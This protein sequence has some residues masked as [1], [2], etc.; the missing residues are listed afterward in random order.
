MRVEGAGHILTAAYSVARLTFGMPFG[1]CC[2]CQALWEI[3]WQ[4][5]GKHC[6]DY[7]CGWKNAKSWGGREVAWGIWG[8]QGITWDPH[9]WYLESRGRNS[10]ISNSSK[11]RM[12]NEVWW[13]DYRTKRNCDGLK[14]CLYS[15]LQL[16]NFRIMAP[17]TVSWGTYTPN[18]LFL[19]IVPVRRSLGYFYFRLLLLIK[20]CNFPAGGRINLRQWWIP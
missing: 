12:V 13:K 2:F 4:W 14:Q 11:V 10:R 15:F 6:Q 16:Q 17:A 8:L 9:S 7:H 5:H 3:Y 20:K 18:L 1:E 19:I